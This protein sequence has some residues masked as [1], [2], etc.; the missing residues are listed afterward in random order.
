MGRIVEFDIAKGIGIILVVIGHQNIP[1]SVTNWI[2]SFH[3]P[4]FFI[5]SGFFFSSKRKFYEI[6][7]RRVK[8]L[9]IPYVFF[10]AL[11]FILFCF[12]RDNYYSSFSFSIGQNL[13]LWFLPVL[14]LSELLIKLSYNYRFSFTFVCFIYSII[15]SYFS[16]FENQ[17][18]NLLLWGCSL[19]GIGVLIRENDL[20]NIIKKRKKIFVVF[21]FI[22][23]ITISYMVSPTLNILFNEVGNPILTP[24]GIF[25]GCIYIYSLSL[26]MLKCNILKCLLSRLGANT[27]LVLCVHQVLYAYM[28]KYIFCD[29]YMMTVI[30][31]IIGLW[32]IMII[33][34]LFFNK[35]LRLV[36]G[37]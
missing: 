31:R 20:L 15:N 33:L 28:Q 37:K 17:I 14:F 26:F 4:L 2:F 29:S 36:I 3:M 19:Y 30:L 13:A 11:N 24:L 5:L 35:Y 10:Y 16:L 12:L 8:S 27:L 21:S 9:I 6:F 32:I 7:K 1:H 22:G 18:F 23:S 34:I 25:F